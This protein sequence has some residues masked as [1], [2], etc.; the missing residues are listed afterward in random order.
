GFFMHNHMAEMIKE[1][2]KINHQ[3]YQNLNSLK[4]GYAKQKNRELDM[5]SQL[6][7]LHAGQLSTNN[8]IAELSTLTG[9]YQSIAEQI[10]PDASATNELKLQMEEQLALQKQIQ[11]Q[12]LK[13]EENQK[14]VNNRLDN[15]E[16][17]SEKIV[18]QVDYLRSILF[19]RTNDLTEKIEEGF[20]LTS[21]YMHYI[22]T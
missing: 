5:L 13:Q 22:L 17:L 9:F 11:E 6:R 4:N 1:Q 15:Q 3:L 7:E 2:K 10:D 20:H 21:A 19:E 8:M 14:E 12:L 16:A 18:R